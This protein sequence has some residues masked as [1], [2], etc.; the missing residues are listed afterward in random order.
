VAVA[1]AVAVVI[2]AGAGW[3]LARPDDE[4]STPRA[5]GPVASATGGDAPGVGRSSDVTAGKGSVVGLTLAAVRAKC[6]EPQ[7]ARL[8]ETADFAFA[9]TVTGIAGNV[10]TLDVTKVYRGAAAGQARVEQAGDSSEQMLGS[11]KFE[12]GKDYLVAAA[13]GSVMI[14]GY[15]G[16]ADLP[17]L[18]ELFE[19]AF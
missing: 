11:G 17:G 18:R 6:R 14:C 15:S 3:M 13:Q 2:A 8:A 10:V 1:A 16:E 19:K 4:R 5:G 12:T 7:A 9:G